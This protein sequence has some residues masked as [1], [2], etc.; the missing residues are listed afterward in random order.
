[1]PNFAE[2]LAKRLGSVRQAQK[3]P[4]TNETREPSINK[5][6]GNILISSHIVYDN[7]DEKIIPFLF[8]LFFRRSIYTRGRWYKRFL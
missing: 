4:I 2:E 3:P 5:F 8:F 6:K 7:I 1:M